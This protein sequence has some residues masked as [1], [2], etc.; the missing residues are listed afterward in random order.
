MKRVKNIL[1]VLFWTTL[2]IAAGMVIVFETNMVEP[3]VLAGASVNGEFLVTIL[4]ELLTLASVPLALKLFH[5]RR[6]RRDLV[7]RKESSLLR[8][9]LIRLSMLS[10][11][12]VA[13]T[14]LYYIYMVTAFGY[15]ALIIVICLPFVYPSMDRCLTETEAEPEAEGEPETEEEPGTMESTQEEGEEQ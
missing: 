2:A 10:V 6:I 12:L 15:M 14:L 8:W 11:I 13:N 7:T 1:S 5:F 3:G 9:G 4:M